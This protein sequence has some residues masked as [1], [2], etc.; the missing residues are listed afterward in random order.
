[1]PFFM[2]LH[3]NKTIAYKCTSPLII[4]IVHS[5]VYLSLGGSIVPQDSTI[6]I[7]DIG[8]SSPNQLVC[9]SDRKL[10]CQNQPQYG[11]WYLYPNRSQVAHISERPTPTAFHCDRNNRGEI[12]LYRTATY[13]NVKSP[14]GQFCCETKDSDNTTRTL[15][16]T[17]CEYYY[18]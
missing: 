1:M 11:G 18:T 13:T 16:V 2:A 6:F 3:T 4:L 14:V 5:G 9:V 8:I 15:C 7:N 17:V 10:C 12:S